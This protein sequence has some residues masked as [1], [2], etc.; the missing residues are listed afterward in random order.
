MGP[1]VSSIE[2]SLKNLSDPQIDDVERRANSV[3]WEAHPVNI[4][5]EQAESVQGLRKAS[6]RA[7]K[8]RIVEI[9]GLDRSACG[10]THVRSTAELGP[11]QVLRYE[12]VRGNIRVEFVCGGRAL[13]HAKQE[14][15]TLG[16]LSR[17]ASTA[18]DQLP[19]YFSG[20]KDRLSEA[21]KAQ[22]RLASEL[23]RREGEQSYR[24]TVPSSDGIR[25]WALQ[26]QTIDEATR[27]KAQA[28]ARL[29]KALALVTGGEPPGILLACSPDSE[30]NAGSLLKEALSRA[31]GRG[32]GSS[33]LA[34]G[35][36]PD[37]SV[38]EFLRT[39]LGF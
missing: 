38:L 6:G 30:I 19:G 32:G 34:Q 1:E 10:G 2:L 11:I 15:R 17:I 28:F 35:G 23:A 5:F 33:T 9:N 21:E 31:G 14:H 29:P 18:V 25:R 8:L 4:L 13:R 24:D 37:K 39:Q 12:R 7:G 16:E 27:A 22:Q 26:A 36:L 20:I 3:V